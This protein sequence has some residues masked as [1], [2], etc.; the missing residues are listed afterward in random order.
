MLL[1]KSLKGIWF[2]KISCRENTGI[3]KFCQ[4]TGTFV[5]SSCKFPD[6]KDKGYCAIC[7][8][9]LSLYSTR[10]QNIWR[11][12][13]LRRLMQKIV[14]LRYLTQ[15]ILTCWYLW[16]WVKQIFRVLSDAKPKICVTP[17]A[18]PR[19]QSV[20]YRWRWVPTQNA[21]VGHV[22]FFFFV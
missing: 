14:L 9:I 19:R 5:C 13:L 20:E 15:K 17:D 1:E 21:G 7:R 16:R 18:N 8:K 6:S 4:S 12:V 2:V 3:W 22:Y 10:T 11:R